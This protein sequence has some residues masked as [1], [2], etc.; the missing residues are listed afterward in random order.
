MHHDDDTGRSTVTDALDQLAIDTIRGLSIDMVQQANSGH[1]GTPLGAAPVAY[2]LWNRVLRYD[3]AD[4]LW[5][6]R[7]RFVLSAGHASALLWSLL[8][9]AGVAAVGPEAAA[10]PGR[11]QA[12]TL[13][14]IRAF[15][16]LGSRCPGHPEHGWTSGVE[17]TTGPLGQGAANSVG[18]ALAGRWLAA[19]YNR[20]D[21][22]LFTHDVYALA[23]DGCMMEGIASEAASFAGHQRL[24][25]L[26][27]FYDANR[28][29]ID[30]HTDITFTEDVVARFEAYGWNIVTVA[31]ANDT[32]ALERALHDFRSEDERPT[33]IVVHSH[34]GYGSPV[35][36]RAKAHGEPL[37]TAGVAATKELL[38]LPVDAPF[39]VD[40]AVRD[41][42]AAGI[43]A[44]GAAARA[45]WTALLAAY[46][47]AHPAEAAE[48]DLLWAGELPAGWD[49]ALPTF[50]PD[51]K[52]LATRVSSATVLNAVGAA[53]PWLVGGS[54]D[55]ASSTKTTLVAEGMGTMDAKD[56]GGRNLHFG[57]REHASA[58]IC[59]GLALSGLQPY[60]SGFL[61]FS[62]YARG[63][64][65]LSALMEQ[66]V[67]HIFTHDSIAVGEDGPTHQPIEQLASL[68]ALPGVLV[69]RPADAN[70]VTE[71]WRALLA[72]RNEPSVLA[73]SRQ[74]LPTLD[75]TSL[76][77]ADGVARGAYVLAEATGGAPSVLLL[78]TGAEVHLALAARDEL[79]AAGVP[80]RVVSLPCWELFERES[81]AYRDEV[82]PPSVRARVSIEAAADLGWARWTGDA[83]E[84]VAMHGFGASAPLRDLLP[85]FGFTTD[86]VVAA[87][88]R[89]L[90]RAAR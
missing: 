38:G 9:L 72:H 17:T 85:H 14:D 41:R 60:W 79:E 12:V 30:G 1:P 25:N 39:W 67:T 50:E 47:A 44:R 61:I 56:P 4:P 22:P 57:I 51:A 88:H 11:T 27:W 81:E 82:L 23:G 90:E 6:D 76:G 70:E 26:C 20:P 29:T 13:D 2:T 28:V 35:E 24:A 18:M 19:R 64:I 31:D 55:L 46:R 87:A 77:A 59:S 68:R 32:A 84:S 8:H 33:L 16:Q 83:G 34:I 63:A 3:P 80:T 53:V 36:D 43:G 40:D 7:D 45:E 58:A 89:S 62:D 75:R 37:G 15:R 48:L 74:D 21:F 52:G 49:A 66:P 10:E 54:A 5:P 65:R 73:L 42:F 69:F 71:S 78:A 86:A